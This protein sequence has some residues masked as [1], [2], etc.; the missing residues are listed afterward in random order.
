MYYEPLEQVL[1]HLGMSMKNNQT[2]N[3][4]IDGKS[5]V[6]RALM[7]RHST[8]ANLWF[9]LYTCTHCNTPGEAQEVYA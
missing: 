3:T 7:P 2:V 8:N 5:A 6:K 1:L 4:S 9:D